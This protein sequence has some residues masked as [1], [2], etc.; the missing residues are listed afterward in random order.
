MI[1]GSAPRSFA[2]ER[3][4]FGRLHGREVAVTASAPGR[5]NLIGDHTDYNGGFVLPRGLPQ[6]T[7][8]ALAPRVDGRVRAAS[9]HWPGELCTYELGQETR[10]RGWIDY[11]QGVT[12]TLV[13]DRRAID[14]FDLWVASDIPVGAGLASSAALA[15][16]LLRGL[17]DLFDL[18]LDDLALALVAHR[19]ESGFVGVPVGVMDPLASSLGDERSALFID[20][21]ALTIERVALPESLGLVVIDSGIDH[22]LGGGDYGARRAEC[23][24][25]AARLGVEQLRDLPEGTDLSGLPEPLAGRV[26]HVLAEN[27]RVTAAV[28]AL[29]RGD[30]AALGALFDA[31]HR[32]LSEDFAVSLPEI[33]R[34]A[35]CARRSGALGARLTGG[36][37]GGSIVAVTA[38]EDAARVARDTLRAYEPAARRPAVILPWSH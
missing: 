4:A 24:E 36:G 32:S 34:L 7:R 9:A 11:V 12:A 28:D 1:E 6:H 15:V 2:V 25:A 17:R 23:T 5:V 27:A 30:V 38:A 22:K 3:E 16:A 21:R 26:R 29:R 31:S 19:A 20:T 14:G 13:E 33:D 37:F 35:A 18:E 8:V 10:A